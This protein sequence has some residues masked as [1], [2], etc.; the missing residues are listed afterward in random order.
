[1]AGFVQ[2][3]QQISPPAAHGMVYGVTHIWFKSS[4]QATVDERKASKRRYPFTVLPF[5]K[6]SR[7]NQSQLLVSPASNEGLLLGTM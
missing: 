1:M 2:F 6:S 3:F 4:L 5:R 7:W